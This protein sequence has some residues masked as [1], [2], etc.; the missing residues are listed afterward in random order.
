MD[1]FHGFLCRG[2]DSH[3]WNQFLGTLSLPLITSPFQGSFYT[4][5]GRLIDTGEGIMGIE[6]FTFPP[7]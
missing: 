4:V 6:L 1:I 5:P 7:I 2:R 3:T